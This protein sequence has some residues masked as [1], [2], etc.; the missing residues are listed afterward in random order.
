ML[1]RKR[2]FGVVCAVALLAAGGGL[3]FGLNAP[4]DFFLPRL[5]WHELKAILE[6]DDV[7][8]RRVKRVTCHSSNYPSKDYPNFVVE[9][10]EPESVIKVGADQLPF[11]LSPGMSLS[12]VRVKR[13]I[14]PRIEWVFRRCYSMRVDFREHIHFEYSFHHSEWIGDVI[15]DG[16]DTG[17][18]PEH[19]PSCLIDD[20]ANVTTYFEA[21]P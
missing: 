13:P 14:N 12:A 18:Y 21:K 3:A 5:K 6:Q 10:E 9:L 4:P 16:K 11:A 1:S 19:I 15:K 17:P 2:Y 20:Q 8:K 7:A